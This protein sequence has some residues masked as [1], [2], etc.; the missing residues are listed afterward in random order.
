MN[1]KT[2]QKNKSAKQI[3]PLKEAVKRVLPYDNWSKFIDKR[4]GYYSP[5]SNCKASIRT[6]TEEGLIRNPDYPGSE[7][8]IIAYT[9]LG[10]YLE[11][12]SDLLA[13]PSKVMQYTRLLDP[14]VFAL[15]E[16][17]VKS[18]DA[19]SI[20]SRRE[21]LRTGKYYYGVDQTQGDLERGYITNI[22]GIADHSYIHWSPISE[23]HRESIAKYICSEILPMYGPLNMG[24]CD[25]A[26]VL[27][28]FLP[29][30]PRGSRRN[31]GWPPLL[32]L[33]GGYDSTDTGLSFIGEFQ[34][35][36][37]N[38]KRDRI[39]FDAFRK[40][41]ELL[42]KC[43]EISEICFVPGILPCIVPIHYNH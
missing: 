30:Q 23:E 14:E 27:K 21:F 7:K 36:S 13:N 6:S 18:S 32:G 34:I 42:C 39:C 28:V 9:D 4:P 41:I 1:T 26:M 35:P 12:Y 10:E 3:L 8:C 43:E 22:F 20:A 5:P 31:D 24:W 33:L 2:I 11:V 38:D 17:Y 37:G 25:G 16:K 40:T 15:L 19:A 29:L